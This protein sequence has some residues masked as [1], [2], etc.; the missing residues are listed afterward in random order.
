MKLLYTLCFLFLGFFADCQKIVSGIVVNEAN[1]QPVS[2]AQ[3]FFNGTSIGTTTNEQG[4]FS[5]KVPFGRHIL[6]AS[7]PAFETF[8]QFINSDEA[9][10]SLVIQLKTK[11]QQPGKAGDG[12]EREGWEKWGDFFIDNFIGLASN[13]CKIKN[14]KVLRF[15]FSTETGDLFASADEPLIIENKILGYTILYKLETF[16]C[17]FKTRAIGYNG[18]S[19]FQPMIGN[20]SQQQNWDKR[21]SEAYLGSLM[22]FM[23]SVYRNKL[24]E[25]GFDVRSLKKVRSIPAKS[26]EVD[27][28][29]LHFS[30]TTDST[31]TPNDIDDQ[32]M[33]PDNYKDVIGMPLPGD[34]IAYAI[35][36]TR[37]GLDFKDFLLVIYRGAAEGEQND[38]NMTSQLALINKRPIEIEADGSFYNYRD[39]IALGYWTWSEKIFRLL[40]FDY[41]P[42]AKK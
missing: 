23:R 32:I 27:S 20:T 35:G 13:Q 5:I 17:N 8:G 38:V 34:S 19:F 39:L 31:A 10:D 3:I 30:K 14:T 29:N 16:V 2:K 36:S 9:H 24:E 1:K 15:Q 22:H 11:S 26:I 18:Y 28:N 21:R 6:V 7:S 40:P 33:N 42:P 12:Y 25:E 4:E 37:A 41:S